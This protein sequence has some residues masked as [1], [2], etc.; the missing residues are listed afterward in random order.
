MPWVF[1]ITTPTVVKAT[2]GTLMTVSVI[3]PGSTA[4]TVNNVTTTG[5]AA[6]TNQIAA[7]PMIPATAN[8]VMQL[9]AACP[10]GIVVVP[11]TGQTVAA[12]YF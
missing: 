1:D 4:G 8:G 9:N 3:V 7:I 12:F 10:A 11:G 2:P 5:D 6:V